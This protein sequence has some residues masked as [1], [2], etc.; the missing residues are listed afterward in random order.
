MTDLFPNIANMADDS[1]VVRL[2]TAKFSKRRSKT[3]LCIP[4]FLLAPSSAGAWVSYG[5]GTNKNLPSHIVL[6]S[7]DSGYTS[8]WS[9]SLVTLFT[10]NSP[11]SI[12]DI[13]PGCRL[14][15]TSSPGCRIK[16]QTRMLSLIKNLI[17]V[18]KKI[19]YEEAIVSSVKN[20]QTAYA[21]QQSFLN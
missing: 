19:A 16:K 5:W 11:G 4:A 7:K 15:P 3:F 21:M 8:W 10:G 2:M 20:A 6:K 9:V 17:N 12:F 1:A 14:F 13:R 18:F